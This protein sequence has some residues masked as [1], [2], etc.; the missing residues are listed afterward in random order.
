ML[1]LIFVGIVHEE[2]SKAFEKTKRTLKAALKVKDSQTNI[3]SSLNQR[4]GQ[5]C[6]MIGRFASN[7]SSKEAAQSPEVDLDSSMKIIKVLKHMKHYRA[8]PLA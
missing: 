5:R 6:D 8:K 3:T 1:I 7:V 2:L 4:G